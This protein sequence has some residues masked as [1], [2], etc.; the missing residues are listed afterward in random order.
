[1][2]T[3]TQMP[4]PGAGVL[5]TAAAAVTM[6]LWASAFIA[7]RAVGAHYSPGAMA[8][9]RLAVGAAALSAVAVFRPV[10]LPRGRPLLLIAAYG[11]L[12]F[13]VYAVLVNAAE[14]HLDAGTTA[15]LINV[16]PILIAV[17]AGLYLREGFPRP[18]VTGLVIAFTGVA[19]IAVA[20]STG[21]RDTVGV[22]LA[23]GA[24]GLY[25]TGVLLQKQALRHVDPF[26]AT[27][28]G[29]VAGMAVCL[30]FA[31]ALGHQVGAAPF[32]ATA[33]IVY[34]GLFPTA[35]AFA[36][37]SYALAHTTAGRLS[38]SSYL[39]PGLAVLMSWLLLAEA[40][41]PLALAGGALCLVGVA[42]ARLPAR[43]RRPSALDTRAGD[44]GDDLPL[45]NHENDQQGQ[46]ADDGGGHVLGVGDA[47]GALHHA[48]THR[49]GHDRR[50]GRDDERP[51]EVV[52]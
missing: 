37:W 44:T 36:T 41:A 10:R 38:S 39:V 6:V 20:T 51:Q 26:T 19:T 48:E 22:F 9:G 11:A 7:I 52:P 2:P 49:Q 31:P 46:C 4:A 8:F 30:P 47:V 12:W 40:P 29:C 33:G 13:G 27:W 24:A 43:P 34:M 3:Q 15:L 14:R 18:L 23:L 25:A 32:A 35:V 17:F 45:E 16:G 1:M 21:Q 42:V 5:P 28:L 50:V